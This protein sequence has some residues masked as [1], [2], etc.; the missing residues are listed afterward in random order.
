VRE[1]LPLP[2]GRVDGSFELPAR[3]Q[4]IRE[5]LADRDTESLLAPFD[6]LAREQ[7]FGDTPKNPLRRVTTQLAIGRQPPQEVD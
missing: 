4:I 2:K 3:E 6:H 7:A 5:P 1:K